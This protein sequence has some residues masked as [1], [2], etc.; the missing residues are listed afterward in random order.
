MKVSVQMF[1]AAR[2]LSG[3]SVVQIELPP[4]STLR[5]LRAALAVEAP[6]IGALLPHLKFAVNTDYA[7]EETVIPAG[8]EVACIPPV[9]GG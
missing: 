8:A 7:A 2:Q 5:E 6:T 1:A 9:S 4:G 3:Q